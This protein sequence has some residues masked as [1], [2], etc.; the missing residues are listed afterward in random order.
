[1]STVHD[2]AFFTL[3]GNYI[4]ND[5]VHNF[6]VSTDKGVTWEPLTHDLDSVS[7]GWFAMNRNGVILTSVDSLPSNFH[8]TTKSQMMR[9]TDNGV[10][11]SM[12]ASPLQ[13]SD[14]LADK[15]MIADSVGYFYY[16]T[17]YHIYRT[18]N[19]GTSWD[20]VTPTGA[21]NFSEVAI[22]TTGDI[23]VGQSTNGLG[24]DYQLYR[25]RDHGATWT[26]TSGPTGYYIGQIATG[27]ND[28]IY[29]L[30][31]SGPLDTTL[32]FL[33]RSTDGGATWEPGVPGPTQIL[34]GYGEDFFRSPTTGFLYAHIQRFGFWRSED[35][36]NHWEEIDSGIVGAPIR[37]VIRSKKGSLL[38]GGV[39]AI[40]RHDG[41]AWDYCDSLQ[42]P[43]GWSGYNSGFL[44]APDGSLLFHLYFGL[45][46]STDEG[47]SWKFLHGPFDPT[48]VPNRGNRVG[49][50]IYAIDSSSKIYTLLTDNYYSTRG[51]AESTDWGQSWQL[52]TLPVGMD[53]NLTV[54]EIGSDQSVY[55]G[56][57]S[58]LYRLT[59]GGSSWQPLKTIGSGHTFTSVSAVRPDL[60]LAATDYEGVFRS[61]DH[62][63][64]WTQILAPEHDVIP[65]QVAT[66]N[67][68]GPA[69][70][71]FIFVSADADTGLTYLP[72]VIWASE[73]RG[74]GFASFD[75]GDHWTVYQDSIQPYY[76]WFDSP[77]SLVVGT[78]VGGVWQG[79]IVNASVN[80]PTQS[81]AIMISPNPIRDRASLWLTLASS[82][83]VAI[84]LYDE[85][86]RLALP[87]ITARY[88]AGTY[89][90]PID[91][92]K[93]PAGAYE[94][95][96][97][98]N[99]EIRIAKV[100]V[101]K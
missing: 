5:P 17:N 42:D 21:A 43:Y 39:G 75:G 59:S 91:V 15:G 19:E 54:I 30:N 13:Q 56:D 79:S 63:A 55:L 80:S 101:V 92:S 87:E 10:Q 3:D 70:S 49:A 65:L 51:L 18:T 20:T 7:V 85:T 12:V 83:T 90:V 64:T 41:N 76:V 14:Y 47:N 62:G 34:P 27:P 35:G 46:R 72:D 74:R 84:E 23:L 57:D 52:N 2:G 25:S 69:S 68:S 37:D 11:W 36:G 16:V 78:A 73:L 1:S 94:L 67:V 44:N 53:T 9:S 97:R 28:T 4:T 98:V 89:E 58:T 88:G 29:N 93:L 38:A 6:E 95:R 31:F 81:S 96:S 26:H 8:F 40:F 82:Q 45:Y 100:I 22:T 24:T 77:T 33:I 66:P 86:G 60:L 71:A 99:D 48:V 32:P 61:L 50:Q